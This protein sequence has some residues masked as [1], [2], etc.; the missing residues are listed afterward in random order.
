M[1]NNQLKNIYKKKPLAKRENTFE[2]KKLSLNQVLLGHPDHGSTQK[3]NRVSLGFYLSRS[4][5]LPGAVWVDPPS[6]FGF[7]NLKHK[8]DP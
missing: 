1:I 2:K 3:V 8:N 7:N 6:R 5:A 4:F